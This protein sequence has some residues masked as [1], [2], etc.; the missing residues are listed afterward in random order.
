[1]KKS[2]NFDTRLKAALNKSLYQKTKY[3]IVGSVAYSSIY[4]RIY[5]AK[6]NGEDAA[7]KVIL[8]EKQR[9]HNVYQ[10][11]DLSE[12]E[13]RCDPKDSYDHELHALQ[14][15]RNIGSLY[16][17][18]ILSDGNVVDFEDWEVYY[19]IMKKYS[20]LIDTRGTNKQ[21]IFNPLMNKW[22]AEY[23]RNDTA[24][25]LGCCITNAFLE[26][27]KAHIENNRDIKPEN[28][29]LANNEEDMFLNR[30]IL[31]DF[32]ESH[33]E[34]SVI[35]TAQAHIG[36]KEYIPGN[37][38]PNTSWKYDQF[39]LGVTMY[40]I[41]NGTPLPPYERRSEDENMR[42]A[43]WADGTAPIP[44]PV[45]YE[46]DEDLFAIIKRMTMYDPDKRY[47]NIDELKNDLA[48]V[49]KNKEF[50]EKLNSGNGY[51]STKK[52]KKS[53]LIKALCA[54]LVV[55]VICSS[56]FFGINRKRNSSES[57]TLFEQNS[58]GSTESSSTNKE[59]SS[60]IPLSLE[61]INIEYSG[62]VHGLYSQDGL[63]F[64]TD[65]YGMRIRGIK[66]E[67]GQDVIDLSYQKCTPHFMIQNNIV[68]YS[69]Q[70]STEAF[71]NV[72]SQFAHLSSWSTTSGYK[73]S[74]DGTQ[75]EKLIDF[76]GSGYFIYTTDE[77]IYYADQGNIMSDEHAENYSLYRLNRQTGEKEL[78]TDKTDNGYSPGNFVYSNDKIFYSGVDGTVDE[79]DYLYYYDI[80]SGEINHSDFKILPGAFSTVRSESGASSM[81]TRLVNWSDSNLCFI[82]AK[83]TGNVTDDELSETEYD[84]SL[85]KYN[86][87]SE[88]TDVLKN[89]GI[90]KALITNKINAFD[91]PA[92]GIFIESYENQNPE[93]DEGL[94][95]YDE[96]SGFVKLNNS[97][98]DKDEFGDERKIDIS[99]FIFVLNKTDYYFDIYDHH[100]D[101]NEWLCIATKDKVIKIMYIDYIPMGINIGNHSVVIYA[102]EESDNL[103]YNEV[104]DLNKVENPS[105]LNSYLFNKH[106]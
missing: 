28:L 60:Q 6:K 82:T 24:A 9:E 43:D 32:G 44:A 94:Y 18:E 93:I 87:V 95:Y 69:V 85:V 105:Y 73:V 67:Y 40:E 3:R 4:T 59:N 38:E 77:Y 56:V 35:T 33:P 58:L 25:Y 90:C 64:Y 16:A 8:V 23:G 55:A 54:V 70:K 50:S 65:K 14:S 53:F 1:M 74:I 5:N 103:T 36:T 19:F 99:D 46:I 57:I 52:S 88:K 21:A 12:S 51:N 22:I 13:R 76:N 49:I 81:D 97:L 101:F 47:D 42:Y 63:D 20:P 75:Y 37:Q 100:H 104:L 102:T 83:E 17:V 66:D 86:T 15:L 89:L 7:V 80:E 30:F 26:M 62:V 61:D 98:L 31:G 10:H 48:G 71:E 41:F 27:R 92:I 45:K 72:E 96:E 34:S 2:E 68:Y 39:M 106:S 29:Y 84:I 91:K 11:K 79:T 78:I